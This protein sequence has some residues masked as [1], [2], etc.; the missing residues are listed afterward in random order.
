MILG[1]SPI[2]AGL[3]MKGDSLSFG[4]ETVVGLEAGGM[5]AASVE[6]DFFSS[7]V[8]VEAAGL[9]T[10]NGGGVQAGAGA[11]VEAPVA[12]NG[13]V[14]VGGRGSVFVRACGRIGSAGGFKGAVSGASRFSMRTL[15]VWLSV[16]TGSA[17]AIS[18]SIFFIGE[19][20]RGSAPEPGLVEPVEGRVGGRRITPCIAGRVRVP[21]VGVPVTMPGALIFPVPVPLGFAVGPT[22][23]PVLIVEE[24]GEGR[25]VVV[26]TLGVSFGVTATGDV[27]AAGRGL[28][29]GGCGSTTGFAASGD[30]LKG[31][32]WSDRGFLDLKKISGQAM[33]VGSH[34]QV[35][36]IKPI[37]GDLP[38][39]QCHADLSAEAR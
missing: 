10:G 37:Q 21:E 34:T 27:I 39:E 2:A 32:G 12:G 22:G 9:K 30:G 11:A 19:A 3:R 17:S 1:T 20:G 26:M 8:G 15:P 4:A 16:L 35:Q 38:Q 5:R 24:V 18:C 29:V 33:F 36:G 31:G 7:T 23:I 6:S 13:D 14:S 25:G 28:T